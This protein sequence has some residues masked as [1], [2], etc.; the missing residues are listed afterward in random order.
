MSSFS[1]GFVFLRAYIKK[2]HSMIWK[3]IYEFNQFEAIDL[4]MV[5]KLRQDIFIIEQ[6]CIYDDIDSLDI[7]STHLLLYDNETLAGYCRIVPEGEKF[8]APSIGRVV[9]NPKYRSLGK[10]KELMNKALDLLKDQNESTV[11][12]EA[13]LYLE[14]FYESLGFVKRSDPYEVD[15]ITHI[16]M[17]INLS[18]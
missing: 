9:I 17:D 6:N 10:G 14:R 7:I 16:L 11:V 1:Y 8:N 3:I 2:V 13:Q 18:R 5:L 4:Y 12:I 15:G